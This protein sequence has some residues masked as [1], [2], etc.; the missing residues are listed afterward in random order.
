MGIISR[1]DKI[2]VSGGIVAFAV[3]FG[4]PYYNTASAN[5]AVGAPDISDFTKDSV[6]CGGG[7]GRESGQFA[8]TDAKVRP[9]EGFCEFLH[10]VDGQM[11]AEERADSLGESIGIMWRHQ[12]A[13]YA[14][15]HR[16]DYAARR[17][18]HG[19]QAVCRR[20]DRDHPEA[21]GVAWDLPDREDMDRCSPVGLR[22]QCRLGNCADEMHL[23]LQPFGACFGQDALA[24]LA[25]GSQSIAGNIANYHELDIRMCGRDQGQNITYELA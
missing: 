5:A 2:E 24:R 20:F 25:P 15:A 4:F 22:Q 21:L 12:I 23:R 13:G 14:I 19:G 3:V 8:Q 10:R 1:F 6:L 17:I 16:I 7:I 11:S 18:T 9:S